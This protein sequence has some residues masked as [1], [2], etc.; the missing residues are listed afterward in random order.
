[1]KDKVLIRRFV[2]HSTEYKNFVAELRGENI[3]VS[4]G[5]FLYE[6]PRRFNRGTLNIYISQEDLPKFKDIYKD[7]SDLK[8]L[9]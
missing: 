3:K 1:M 5:N 8:R 9:L 7:S 6:D 2:S 4:V